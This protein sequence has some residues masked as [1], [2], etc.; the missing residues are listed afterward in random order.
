MQSCLFWVM[1]FKLWLGKSFFDALSSARNLEKTNAE[2]ELMLHFAP[3]LY[4]WLQINYAN[5]LKHGRSNGTKSVAFQVLI[6]N[7]QKE[8][9]NLFIFNYLTS[10][11][12][13][14]IFNFLKSNF[15]FSKRSFFA[16]KRERRGFWISNFNLIRKID[17]LLSSWN[18]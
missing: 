16:S 3:G 14:F 17:D 8:F 10:N 6:I 12:H 2:Y 15:S 7:Y 9:Q 18:K 11:I 13:F 1:C 5:D 4:L